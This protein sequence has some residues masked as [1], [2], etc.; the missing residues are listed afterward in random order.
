MNLPIRNAA[1]S[2]IDVLARVW[3][4]AWHEAHAAHVPQELVAARTIDDFRTRLPDLLPH[5]RT[6]GTIGSPLGLCIIRGDEMHQLFLAPEA[7]GTGIAS[8]LLADAERRIAQS[9]VGDAWLDVLIENPR[10][11]RFYQREGWQLGEQAD[12]PLDTAEGTGKF[13]LCV[14]IMTKRLVPNA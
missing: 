6:V 13:V 11:I 12:M 5:L 4:D 8:A 1:P 7:R 3:Y 14:Q 9:G 10:A 2:E